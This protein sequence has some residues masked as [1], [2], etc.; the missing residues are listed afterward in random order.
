MKTT[1]ECENSPICREK[2]QTAPIRIQVDVTVNVI[3]GNQS[4]LVSIIRRFRVNNW[5]ICSRVNTMRKCKNMFTVESNPNRIRDI[6]V[7]EVVY[8][9]YKTNAGDLFRVILQTWFSLVVYIL[10]AGIDF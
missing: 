8:F 5:T 3:K 7:V 9:F 1:R 10:I 6:G 2:L 4:I